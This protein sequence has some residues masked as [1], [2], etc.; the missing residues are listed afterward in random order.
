MYVG[1]SAFIITVL[2]SC[3][4]YSGDPDYMVSSLLSYIVPAYLLW[5]YIRAQRV[6]FYDECFVVKKGDTIERFG[7]SGVSDWGYSHDSRTPVILLQMKN[8]DRVIRAPL[9]MRKNEAAVLT[10]LYK[11]AGKGI[12]NTTGDVNFEKKFKT[13]IDKLHQEQNYQRPKPIF[14]LLRIGAA[15]YC[16]GLI[17]CVL[18]KSFDPILLSFI[19]FGIVVVYAGVPNAI[20]YREELMPNILR[21]I[22]HKPYTIKI[23]GD[24]APVFRGEHRIYS[25]VAVL[26]VPLMAGALNAFLGIERLWF[27]DYSLFLY[28]FDPAMSA[29]YLFVMFASLALLL[30]IIVAAGAQFFHSGKLLVRERRAC[31]LNT[32][33]TSLAAACWCALTISPYSVDLGIAIPPA[34]GAVAMVANFGWLAL[35]LVL[36]RRP[37]A[38]PVPI[39]STSITYRI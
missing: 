18:L 13:D 9:Y 1:M 28:V 27:F 26:A 34:L 25:V 10:L 35:V 7:Y 2:V 24:A 6:E 31:L 5:R 16:I 4:I 12:F 37:L 17:M 20:Y 38:S 23:S 36:M 21:M 22:E 33:L 15:L 11:K 30:A 8:S 39:S 14:R 29:D 19:G 32:A 3:A